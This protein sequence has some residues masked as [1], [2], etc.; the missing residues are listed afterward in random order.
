[1]ND[2]RVVRTC[3]TC[4]LLFGHSVRQHAIA[5]GATVCPG[6]RESQPTGRLT[7]SREQKR[8]WLVLWGVWVA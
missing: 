5:F 7:L 4:G 1:M 3:G 8:R 2:V 6:C